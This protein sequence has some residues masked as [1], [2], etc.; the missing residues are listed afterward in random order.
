M[1]SKHCV[2]LV[3]DALAEPVVRRH[4]DDARLPALATLLSQGGSL[5]PCTSIF[6]SIT[7]AATCSIATGEYPRRHGIE[8]A[9]WFDPVSND[10]AYF[11]DDLR[12]A[13][14]E[15][16]KEYLEDFGDRLNFDRLRAPLIYEHLFDADFESACINYMWFRGPHVH[17][18]TTPLTLKLA[19][20]RLGSDVR[21]PKN[22][23]V[24][25]FRAQFSAWHRGPRDEDRAARSLRISRPNHCSL[26][27]GTG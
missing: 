11:G 17:S 5:K 3:V 1:P 15:G 18:R 22:P 13:L 2:L 6:P 8:G 10:A 24:R 16:L 4:L 7:P 27:D 14:Q 9:C 26:H 19:A 21:G 25:R 20:G 23:E 12:F